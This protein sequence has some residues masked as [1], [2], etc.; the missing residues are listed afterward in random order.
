M[1]NWDSLTE[2]TIDGIRLDPIK[3]EL[4]IEVTCVFLGEERK[5]LVAKGVEDVLLTEMRM[6]NII[7]RITRLEVGGDNCKEVSAAR[8]LFFMMRGREPSEADLQWPELEK[9]LA[10]VRNGTL[11]LIELEPV[12]GASIT[13]LAENIY[14]E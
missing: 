9:K 11:T 14:L 13:I 7:D 4:R 1:S 2:A 6:S 8:S 10:Q 5:Q 3:K 12:Y